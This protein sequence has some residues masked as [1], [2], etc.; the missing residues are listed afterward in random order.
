MGLH[1]GALTY[2]AQEIPQIDTE[3]A[4]KG[5]LLMETSYAPVPDES[6]FPLP[7]TELHGSRIISGSPGQLI[8]HQWTRLFAA[9]KVCHPQPGL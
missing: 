5:Y 4:E 3:I 7:W 6:C 9:G 2:A 1:G 8:I